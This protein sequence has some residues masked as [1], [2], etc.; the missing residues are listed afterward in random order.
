[1]EI[2]LANLLYHFDWDVPAEAAID[3]AGIDMA[4]AFGLSVQLEE[5]LLLVPIEYKDS[6]D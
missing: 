1:M 3:K 5:K 4:E 2:I 6:M